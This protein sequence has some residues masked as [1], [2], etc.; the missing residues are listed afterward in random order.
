M[1]LAQAF[2]KGDKMSKIMSIIV[3]AL[4]LSFCGSVANAKVNKITKPEFYSAGKMSVSRINNWMRKEMP[5]KI[6]DI[7]SGKKNRIYLNDAWKIMKLSGT[8]SGFKNDFGKKNGFANKNYNDK[9]WLNQPVPW[10]WNLVF[11]DGNLS[12]I[13]FTGIG[14]YRKHVSISKAL[15]NKCFILH[16]EAIDDQCEV[17]IN[18][19]KVAANTI[20]VSGDSNSYGPR[21]SESFE[22][23]I[24]K[25]V[26]FGSDNV[27]AVK[28][29][30]DGKTNNRNDHLKKHAGVGGIWQEVYIDVVPQ[31]Y[32]TKT[33]VSPK[34][35]ESG[36]QCKSFIVNTTGKS[37][38]A[39]SEGKTFS[40]EICALQV[41]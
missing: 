35:K 33:L 22:A 15:K 23:D 16:F 29:Y 19:K 13:K 4:M 38:S 11:P 34:L 20:L 28:V 17:F 26:S 41:C 14:W 30:D 32:Q 1:K 31:V 37:Y 21:H 24:T 10:M 3:V 40:L 25:Y 27:I 9:N 12:T 6:Y 7:W 36:L 2:Y 5:P 18:G 8:A 39:D